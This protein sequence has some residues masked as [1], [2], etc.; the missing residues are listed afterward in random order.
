VSTFNVNNPTP[1]SPSDGSNGQRRD[2]P[3]IGKK[4]RNEYGAHDRV[5]TFDRQPAKNPHQSFA[6]TGRGFLPDFH[7]LA[8]LSTLHEA[9]A[10]TLEN[11]GVHGRES[12]LPPPGVLNKIQPTDSGSG[13][14]GAFNTVTAFGAKVNG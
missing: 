6:F 14:S 10:T 13:G 11:E 12:M 1:L 9:S 7:N 3:Y 5:H 4:L 8:G 2:T